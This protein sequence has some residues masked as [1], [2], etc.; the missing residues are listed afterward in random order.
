[1]GWARLCFNFDGSGEWVIQVLVSALSLSCWSPGLGRLGQRRR[2]DK[3]FP[4][5]SSKMLHGLATVGFQMACLDVVVL[6]GLAGSPR[7]RSETL[8][9]MSQSSSRNP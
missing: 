2:F 6:V 7:K 1:M 4:D 8:L 9:S 5:F 3:L